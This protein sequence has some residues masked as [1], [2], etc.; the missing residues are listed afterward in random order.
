MQPV[1]LQS[2]QAAASLFGSSSSSTVSS[3]SNSGYSDLFD[4]IADSYVSTISMD[5]NI[6]SGLNSAQDDLYGS[7]Y[8]GSSSSIGAS[9]LSFGDAYAQSVLSSLMSLGGNSISIDQAKMMLDVNRM[10]VSSLSNPY[11]DIA[12]TTGS[13]IDLLG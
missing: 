2:L 11:G 13:K 10:A 5:S 8:D 9:L 1:S 4:S 7:L 12:N 6:E 3:T